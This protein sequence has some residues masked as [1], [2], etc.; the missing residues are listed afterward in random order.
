LLAA[1]V[2]ASAPLAVARSLELMSRASAGEDTAR[3]AA[4][5]LDSLLVTSDAAEAFHAQNEGRTPHWRGN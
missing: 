2:L 3:A 1:E 4:D 5:V